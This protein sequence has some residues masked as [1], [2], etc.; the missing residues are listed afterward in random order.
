MAALSFVTVVISLLWRCPGLPFYVLELLVN[1]ALVAEVGIRLVAF[2]KNFWK[3]TFNIV[4]LCLV[5]VCIFTLLI[6]FFGHGCSPISR[7]SGAG[8]EL[9][10]SFLL[11]IRNIV[12]CMRL[13]SM[14][15][16]SGYNVTSRI[17]AIDLNDAQ[18]YN[19]DLDLEEESS[20]AQ[21]RMRDGGDSQSHN[22]G[23]TPQSMVHSESAHKPDESI[24]AIDGAYADSDL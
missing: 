7:R 19:L 23:W 16:R 18:G 3:S 5:V 17:S 12:Q 4:D 9:F 1:V 14:I 6:L 22:L 10:D 24:I 15:R 11:I 13:L 21:Q 2:G 8:E 20:L